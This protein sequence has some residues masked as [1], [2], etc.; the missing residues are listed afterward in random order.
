[1]VKLKLVKDS[2]KSYVIREKDYNDLMDI[3]LN[4][5]MIEDILL[6]LLKN[7]DDKTTTV[8]T[9]TKSFYLLYDELSQNTYNL[10]VIAG[11]KIA[12][13]NEARSLYK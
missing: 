1:M 12:S 2:N 6:S 7:D 4:L 8:F 10:G 13:C 9:R 5:R 11:K 3:V